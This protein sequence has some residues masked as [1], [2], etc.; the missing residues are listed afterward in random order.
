MLAWRP[1][2]FGLRTRAMQQ[3]AEMPVDTELLRELLHLPESAKIVGASMVSGSVRLILESDDFPATR[4]GLAMPTA[5]A[6]FVPD[7]DGK[8]VFTDW[9]LTC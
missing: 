9:E 8:P 3:R 1:L 6:I 7:D 2:S 4:G 5:T